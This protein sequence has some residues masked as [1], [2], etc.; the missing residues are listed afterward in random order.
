MD[1]GEQTGLSNRFKKYEEIVSSHQFHAPISRL[2]DMKMTA[3]EPG[4]AKFEL[5][6]REDFL[7]SINTV[8]GGVIGIMADAAMGIS[9]GSLLNDE[10]AFT[11]LEFK[12]NFIRPVS[13]GHLTAVGS[14]PHHGRTTGYTEAVVTNEDGKLV[15]KA[16]GTCLIFPAR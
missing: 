2:L 13:A 8:Q 6:V 11:T 15:A 1:P 9:M 5:D 16:V 4:M 14:V 3:I 12:I 7:N 10:Q